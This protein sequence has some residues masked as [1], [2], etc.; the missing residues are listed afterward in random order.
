M[1]VTELLQDVRGGMAE[2]GG[3]SS[4]R[5]IRGEGVLTKGQEETFHLTE[6]LL[7]LALPPEAIRDRDV[8][9]AAVIPMLL[10]I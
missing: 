1:V 3:C 9:R 8:W 5:D 6:A 4:S 10:E 7:F 2:L